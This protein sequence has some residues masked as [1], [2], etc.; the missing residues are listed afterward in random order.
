MMSPDQRDRTDCSRFRTTEQA[1]PRGHKVIIVTDGL[2]PEEV[3]IF[4]R[5]PAVASNA[6]GS[7]VGRGMAARP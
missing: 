1:I 3:G 5:K 6:L 7:H 4:V 2:A